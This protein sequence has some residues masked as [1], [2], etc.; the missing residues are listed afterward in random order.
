MSEKCVWKKSDEW[1]EYGTRYEM[2]HGKSEVH[3]HW[4]DLCDFESSGFKF[5][6]YCGKE[7][8]V[9]E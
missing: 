2:K 8:E 5:C 3:E 4:F 6:P 7:I 9:N 1:A